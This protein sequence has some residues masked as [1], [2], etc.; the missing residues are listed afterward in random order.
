MESTYVDKRIREVLQNHKALVSFLLLYVADKARHI[1]SWGLRSQVEGIFL[2]FFSW[3][4]LEEISNSEFCIS[5]EVCTTFYVRALFWG[6]AKLWKFVQIKH[7]S[8]DGFFLTLRNI[9]FETW[10]I[11]L[12]LEYTLVRKKSKTIFFA[13]WSQNWKGRQGIVLFGG[14][15]III[16]ILPKFTTFQT[17]VK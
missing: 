17:Y 14:I 11:P 15:G 6:R 10:C 12:F 8:I 16:K 5:S 7:D 1:F 3:E 9:S 13:E 2:I 4:I